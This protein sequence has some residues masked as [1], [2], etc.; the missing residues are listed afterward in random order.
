MVFYRPTPSCESP[1]L[2]YCSVY[3]IFF[4]ILF[5]RLSECFA[6]VDLSNGYSEFEG[7]ILL[8]RLLWTFRE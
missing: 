1:M 3:N 7:L 4:A 2:H 6:T 5:L 8:K